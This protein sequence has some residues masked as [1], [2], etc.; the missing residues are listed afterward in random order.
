MIHEVLRKRD[1]RLILRCIDLFASF[2]CLPKKKEYLT[3][4]STPVTAINEAN[5]KKGTRMYKIVTSDNI[6]AFV[7]SLQKQKTSPVP[8]AFK[9]SAH[10]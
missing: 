2:V 4:D 1:E 6:F 10:E 3:A 7:I 5:S 9:C 8:A